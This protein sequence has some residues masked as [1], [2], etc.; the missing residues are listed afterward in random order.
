RD[1]SSG[2]YLEARIL[3]EEQRYAEA[4]AVVRR[5][6][7]TVPTDPEF[8]KLA[9][10]SAIRIDRLDIAEPA[11]KTAA[12]LAPGDYLVHFHLGALYYTKRSEEHTSELQST[13]NL[14]C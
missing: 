2:L 12:Q 9:A 10:V 8:Y 7:P 13:L 4:L 14:V 6:L 5:A 1:S 11:L 3:F